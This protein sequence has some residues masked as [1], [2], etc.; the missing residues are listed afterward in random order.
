MAHQFPFIDT[1][2][3][4]AANT[5]ANLRADY[6]QF[7]VDSSVNLNLAGV[8]T[9]SNTV[10]FGATVNVTGTIVDDS[11]QVG[12]AGSILSSTGSGVRWIPADEGNTASA[13]NVGT[14]VNATDADQ[15]VAFLGANS[16]NN[17]VRVDAGLTY[18]PSTNILKVED[19]Q[20]P[21]LGK[22]QLG[23]SQDLEL[24]HT[25]ASGGY[26]AIV[27]GG[28]GQLIIGS[29]LLEIK[30]AALNETY[31]TFTGGLSVNLNFNTVERI[32]TADGGVVVTGICT[33]TTF[34]GALTG[35]VTG[36]TSGSS[37]SCTGNAATATALQN[38][39]TI[40]GTSFDGTANINPGVAEGL[41]GTPSIAVTNIDIAGTL[42]DKNDVVGTSG[43][44]LTSTEDGVAWA[45]VGDQADKVAV[46]NEAIDTTC[47]PVFALTATGSEIE[48]KSNTAFK[49]NS[50]TGELEASKF[51]I[52]SG[53]SNQFLKGD[54]SVDTTT[55]L[56]SIADEAITLAKIQHI[57]TSRILGR[58]TA[59][60]GDVEVLAK[61]DVLTLLN[62][63]DGAE[64]NVQSDWN[65]IER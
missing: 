51:A 15:F 64:V 46:A 33:A 60:A 40:G 8:G 39:R 5:I 44:I 45:S 22:I 63:A 27:D 16:G 38:A 23:G 19:I 42:T 65:Q 41:T 53:T 50:D 1:D 54:G 55:Y 11:T 9:F 37:G 43:Q 10:S 26:S 30:N 56:S 20:I 18:N 12:A 49:F 28:T 36:N 31:A 59:S 17:P 47:F 29:N 14:N 57:D 24:Y 21:D 61:S 48:L 4:Q 13:S 2:H 3:S 35:D 6:A 34:I 25:T 62:V 7:G 52:S 32:R 58:T